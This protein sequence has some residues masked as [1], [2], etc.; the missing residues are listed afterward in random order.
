MLVMTAILHIQKTGSSTVNAF[1]HAR[2]TYELFYSALKCLHALRLG[3]VRQV[4]YRQI[5]FTGIEAMTK[6]TAVG[7]LVGIVIITQVANIVGF[8]AVLAGKIFVWTVV[9]ELGPLFSAIIV[10]ARSST[11]VASELG[12]M[13]VNGEVRALRIMGVDPIAYLIVP[14]ILGLTLCVYVLAFYFQLGAVFGG[15]ILSSLFLDIQFLQQFGNIFTALGL[16][17]ISVSFI[18]SLFFGFLIASSSC[19][20]GLRVRSSITEVPQATTRAVMQSLVLVIIFDGIITV[21][22][23]I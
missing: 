9:R 13:Q 7:A 23:S 17:E 6:V 22:F 3:P 10:I 12:S 19:Y 8:N 11:A 15:L 5:Y 2:G 21:L 4:L 16:F 20:H 18:K 1:M 14:R